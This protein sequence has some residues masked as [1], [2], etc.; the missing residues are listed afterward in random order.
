MRAWLTVLAAFLLVGGGGPASAQVT[1]TT[2][3][4]QARPGMPARDAEQPE[5]TGT[6]VIKGHVVAADTGRPLRRAQV[7][8]TSTALRGG[9]LTTTDAE[10]AYE[11]KELPA[12]R[13]TLFASKGGYVALEFGQRRPFESGKPIE[14]LDTQVIDKA[15]LALPRGSA[16]TGRVLDEFGEPIAD[17]FVQALRYQYMNG[18]RR[19][20][21]SGRGGTTN[22]L[23]QYRIYGLP[24][25]E[26][27]VSSTVRSMGSFMMEGQAD[28]STA[29]AP[30]YYPG[31]T[32]AAD[33]QRLSV[34]VGQEAN[35]IDFAL[36]PVRTAKISGVVTTSEGKPAEGAM[37]M[38][39]PRSLEN[40]VMR[41]GGG[42]ARV[43]KDG[44]FTINNVAPGDYV[45]QV[46]TGNARGMTLVGAG[47]VFITTSSDERGTQQEREPE[48][49]SVPVSI[50]GQDITGLAIVTGKGGRLTGKVVF[51]D[52]AAPPHETWKNLRVMPRSTD[53]EM[54][55]RIG[56][57]VE[58]V[59]EDGTFEAKGVSGSV[60]IR[61]IG[62]PAG[63][64]LKRV[65]YNG[66]DITDTP[67]E[68]KGQE[69]ATGVRV[70]L[71]SQTT[72]VTGGVSDDRGQTI[73]DYTVVV[74][75]EDSARW[76]A[77]TRFIS[78][79]R[80][81]QDGRF[82]V[83]DLPPG[84]YLAVALD[85]V[86]QGEWSDPAFLDRIKSQGTAFSLGWGQTKS[87]ALKVTQY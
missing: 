71:T 70:V 83:K 15:D 59:A 85:Y 13:Y 77:P 68:F 43:N 7:R 56:R 78:S 26:Y 12:G 42:A 72:A 19:L 46:R 66:Q 44:T 8:L 60:L 11:F 21:A 73:K 81:D 49:A 34:T 87:L 67:I 51:E 55:S 22:D 76:T 57:G 45:L 86:Q 17:A 64:M 82:Q 10:G 41:M 16:I 74:F 5:K 14:L 2:V 84:D 61:A 32:S 24:P 23:G 4:Q 25:G 50:A 29:Y 63:W 35:G 79:A 1:V 20:M 28:E 38:L 54:F 65:E 47:A 75:A 40:M 30:T 58:P 39:M 69:E 62:L 3:T 48:F 31:T 18:Q 9:R 27:V 36:L 53:T 80:P 33:A 6:A 52:G 37:V